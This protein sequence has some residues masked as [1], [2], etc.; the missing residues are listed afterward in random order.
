MWLELIAEDPLR[1]VIRSVCE[2]VLL[3]EDGL[4]QNDALLEPAHLAK[5]RSG[6]RRRHL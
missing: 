3:G 5:P 2:L 6:S 1:K 4:S